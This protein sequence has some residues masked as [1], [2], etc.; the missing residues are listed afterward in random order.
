MVHWVHGRVRANLIVNV[1]EAFV[2]VGTYDCSV[3][4][5]S[6]DLLSPE[7]NVSILPAVT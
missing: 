6:I 1:M 4:C 7:E 3:V 2:I 5:L